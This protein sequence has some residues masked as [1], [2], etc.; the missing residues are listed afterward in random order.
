M[1]VVITGGRHFKDKKMM[2]SVLD[3]IHETNPIVR[4][5]HGGCTGADNLAREWALEKGITSVSYP[6]D[7]HIGKKAGPMRNAFMLQ[8]EQP[9]YVVAFPGG[10]GTQN[11]IQFAEKMGY[12]VIDAEKVFED[13]NEK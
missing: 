12:V 13:L 9:E 10:R 2:F 3:K 1:N 4:L 6:A 8:K 7:W 11:A 5:A